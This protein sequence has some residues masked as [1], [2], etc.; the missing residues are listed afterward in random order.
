MYDK[1]VFMQ[2][3]FSIFLQM[4][5]SHFRENVRYH[6]YVPENMLKGSRM[7]HSVKASLWYDSL[8]INTRFRFLYLKMS[9]CEAHLMLH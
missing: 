7:G 1:N 8:L 2:L 6:A 9:N 5:W 4:K 3:Y